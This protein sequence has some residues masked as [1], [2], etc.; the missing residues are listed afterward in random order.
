M[1]GF[2][3]GADIS[4]VFSAP[5]ALESD[6]TLAVSQTA[7]VANHIRMWNGYI[8]FS[9]QTETPVTASDHPPCSF[10]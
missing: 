10:I 1:P 3:P 9:S 4:A 7:T 8:T 5:T 2:T 6:E